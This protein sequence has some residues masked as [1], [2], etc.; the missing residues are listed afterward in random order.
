[1]PVLIKGAGVAGLTLAFE[2]SR[3]GISVAV[4][5]LKQQIGQGAS[6]YAGG[7]L[8]PYCEREAAEELVL[9]LG[10]TAADWWEE[11]LP[12]SVTRAGTLVLA[13]TRDLQDLNRFASRTSGHRWVDADEISGL[14]PDLAGRFRKGLFFAEEAHLDP[15]HALAGL[16]HALV[17]QGV[18]FYLGM[19]TEPDPRSFDQVVDC[20]GAAAIERIDTLRGVRGEMIYLHSPDIRLHRPI[21]LLHPRH[22]IYIVPRAD[23]IFMVGATMIEAEDGGPISARSLMEFLNAA[24]TLNSAFGEARVIETGVGI[25]PA[26]ADNL[27]RVIETDEGLAIAGM[28]RHGFLLA[29]AMARQAA[30]RIQIALAGAQRKR[31]S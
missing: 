13:P 30:D 17:E 23:N 11:A 27:P 10:L 3:R 18:P 8:A 24:Y 2:L 21:R 9:T 14:E 5:D 16:H 12:G 28:H 4:H 19:D 22:P 29:P 6:H 25:R 15:R 31:A 1:M 20:T 7:M 26:F